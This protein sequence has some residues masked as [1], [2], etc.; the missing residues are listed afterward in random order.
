MKKL[1]NISVVAALAVLP[2]A[3]NATDL[4]AEQLAHGASADNDATALA[5]T[6]YV[7]GAY[8]EL[9]TAINTKQDKLSEAQLT[10]INDVTALKT[11][12]GDST[13][14][15]VKDV[16]DLNTALD[17]KQDTLTAAQQGA[18]DSGITSAKVT[19]YDQLVTDSANY[20]KKTGVV[21]TINASTVPVITTWGNNTATT[22]NVTSGAYTE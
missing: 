15:L 7:K 3:A 1:L 8:N 9:A 21:A 4:T 13:S 19:S 16:A 6:G 18:V 20:A 11:T 14:G 5:T 12:V 10:A 17:G 22:L 2:M